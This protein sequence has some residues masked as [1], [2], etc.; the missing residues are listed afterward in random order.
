MRDAIAHLNYVSVLV[1]AAVGFVLGWLWYSA[2][3]GKA[4]MAE[5]KITPE[6]VEAAKAKGGMGANFVKSFVFTLLGTFGLAV[7][8]HAHGVPNW[9]HGAAVGLFVGL[10]L[11]VMR[12]LNGAVWDNQTCKLQAINAGHEIVLF[13]L[14]GAILGLWH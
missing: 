12:Y 13:T 6:M 9:K 3:F 10:F 4:W 2:L 14:Q 5:K 11:P 7:V 1:V 8:M